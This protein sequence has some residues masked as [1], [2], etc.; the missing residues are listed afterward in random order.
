M[1]SRRLAERAH[2][3]AVSAISSRHE[4]RLVR[5]LNRFARACTDLSSNHSYDPARNGE[6]R[7]LRLLGEADMRCV[8]DVGANVGNWVTSAAAL[9]PQASFHCFEIVPE[10]ARRLAEHTA[11]LGDRV[12]VNA[13]GLG[14]APATVQ[15]S[16]NPDF[17]EGATATGLQH[18]GLPVDV[19]P[20]EVI[21]GDAYCREHAITHIDLL[22]IDTE[23]L[24]LQVLKGFD[25]LLGGGAVDVV[26]FEYGLANIPVRALLADFYAFLGERDFVVGKI[27]P[28]DIAFRDYNPRTDEDF[29]GPNYLAVRRDHTDLIARLRR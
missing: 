27:W 4:S 13:V 23:G 17:L 19:Q 10:T 29:R 12:H 18:P 11:H 28:H 6:L 14:E 9:L 2:R 1:S 16:I 7:V 15:M 26:Q 8:F 22:K 25:A 3:A 24:D 21:T 20:G 5:G